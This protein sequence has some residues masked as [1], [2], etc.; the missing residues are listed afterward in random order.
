MMG[1]HQPQPELFSYRVNLEKRVRAE[2]P[3][4]QVAA[5][6]DFSFVRAEVAATYG[7]NGNVSIDPLVLLKLML[8][9]FWDDVASERELMSMLAE[10]LDYLWFLGYGLDDQV[11]DHSVLSKARKRWGKEAFE[12]FV[13][14]TT[15][16]CVQR[17]L[18]DGRKLHM[19]SSL[20]QADASKDSVVRSCPELIAAFKKAYQAQESK[21]EESTTPEAYESINDRMVSTTDPDAS[22]TRKSSAPARPSYH[23]HRAMDDARGVITAVETTPGS[24]AENKKLIALIDQHQTNTQLKVETAV[25]DHKYGTAEN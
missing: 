19:D 11:P 5:L 17:G 21:L 10:R 8:L 16:Q 6:I 3:L 25:A 24:I 9:L 1:V 7:S 18:V 23:H 15:T 14:R 22:I 12:K 20:I 2:H 13:T 4:R